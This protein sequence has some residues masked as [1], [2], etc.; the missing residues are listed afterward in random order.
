M[1]SLRI[2]TLTTALITGSVVAKMPAFPVSKVSIPLVYRKKGAALQSRLPTIPTSRASREPTRPCRVTAAPP[3]G[4]V[5]KV[6]NRK[7][8][9]LM[10]RVWYF[11]RATLAKMLYRA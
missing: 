8:Y 9:K 4:R 2:T 5:A 11:C 10:V 3:K 6:A 1:G 7:V